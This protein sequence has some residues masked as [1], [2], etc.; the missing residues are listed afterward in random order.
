MANKL[1]TSR[2][3][4]GQ[5]SIAQGRV[6]ERKLTNGTLGKSVRYGVCALKGQ[7]A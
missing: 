6:S 5:F 4:K 2:G 7:L 1:S 3:L